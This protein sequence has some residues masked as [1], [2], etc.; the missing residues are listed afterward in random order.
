MKNSV[1]IS[2][3]P[4]PPADKLL[5]VRPDNSKFV[6]RYHCG[7]DCSYTSNEKNNIIIK[8]IILGL[9]VH[10]EIYLTFKDF[11]ALFDVFAAE[12]ICS[13]LESSLVKIIP[14]GNILLAIR[15]EEPRIF[16]TLRSVEVSQQ[17]NFF[18][19]KVNKSKSIPLKSRNNII[20][21]T[22]NSIVQDKL[23]ADKVD[24]LLTSEISSDLGNINVKSAL[25]L[26]SNSIDE[27]NS[28]DIHKILRI[29]N[30]CKSLI[31]QQYYNISSATID[32][33]SSAYIGAK[34]RLLHD[35]NRNL[36]IENI[37]DILRMKEMPDLSFLYKKSIISINDILELRSNINGRI[38]REWYRQEDYDKQSLLTALLNSR[39]V[40]KSSVGLVRWI[41][42]N[43]IGFVSQVAGI[44]TSAI[45]SLII[46]KLVSGWNPYMYLDNVL[47]SSID[48]KVKTYQRLQKKQEM[49]NRYGSIG[50][51]SP[52]PCQSGKKYKKCCGK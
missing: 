38:F 37:S 48:E 49:V 20:Q 44:A 5:V 19:E 45:D 14:D 34:S 1:L 35:H 18:E 29:A 2:N 52:C 3:F 24:K 30:I 23:S 9:L 26:K 43:V 22:E 16:G 40:K 12:D 36:S 32:G 51:N 31:Y 15:E 27:V 7:F 28:M 11:I 8:N 4:T 42:P 47:Q 17:F 6:E 13:L 33:Y 21:Y 25:G 46:D 50:R 10:G 41:V 39:K